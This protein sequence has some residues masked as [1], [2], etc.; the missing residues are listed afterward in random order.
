MKP[1][2]VILLDS[3]GWHYEQLHAVLSRSNADV[4]TASLL[5]CRFA[6]DKKGRIGI[7]GLGDALPDAVIVRGIAAGT[8]EQVTLRLDFLHALQE[9][10][11]M[12]YNTARTIERT[13]DKAMT[14]FLLSQ[15]G[16]PTPRAWACESLEQTRETLAQQTRKGGKLVLKPLFGNCGK[17]LQLLGD[18][19]EIPDL[20]ELN[21]VYYLQEFVARQENQGQ[22]WRVMV[23]GGRAI[24]AMERRSETWI[25]NR[26]RGAKCLPVQLD[27]ELATLATCATQAIGAS[28]AGVDVIR[29]RNG[30]FTVLEVNSIPAWRGLQQVSETNIADALVSNLI[31][32]LG[33]TPLHA[34]G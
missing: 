29:N 19:S 12:V 24:S 25:T 27:D 2:I 5:D 9:L 1:N 6:P 28:Y 10:G 8:F 22:D 7:T 33:E 21:G 23:V 14:S 32:Q 3:K 17:G 20:S 18:D 13:V 30:Q 15:A 11:V 4:R 34:V 26:A 31:N 16:V